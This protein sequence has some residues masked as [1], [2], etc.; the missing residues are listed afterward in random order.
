MGADAHAGPV[1]A[2]LRVRPGFAVLGKRA[3]ELVRQVR[4]AAAMTAALGERQVLVLGHVV[5]TLG[6]ELA[7][8]L[9]QQLGLKRAEANL[10]S[11]KARLADESARAQ[12]ALKDWRNMGKTG[13]PPDLVMRKPQLAEAQ[14]AV[15]TDVADRDKAQANLGEPG[16]ANVRV[17]SAKVRLDQA[18]LNLSW[19]SIYAP[20]DGYITNMNLLNS[21]YVSEQRIGPSAA[22]VTI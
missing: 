20:A 6:G 14:A 12:Q 8:A 18:K 7:D 16:E 22:V 15:V 5:D 11:M 13:E 9:G 19:T 17:R 10:A 3:Q 2:L 1:G 21:T 4:V